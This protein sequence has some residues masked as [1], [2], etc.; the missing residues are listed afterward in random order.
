[1]ES[2]E[3]NGEKH[4]YYPDFELDDGT[5]IEIKGYA[6]EQTKAKINSV[7]DRPIKVLF[8]QDLKYA[9]DY[10]KDN[11]VYDKLEDLFEKMGS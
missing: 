10:V 11:Y 9:F 1:M 6:N 5:I 7:I 8:K 2:Y 3:Y 4:R